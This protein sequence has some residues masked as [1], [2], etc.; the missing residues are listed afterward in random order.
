MLPLELQAP[1]P[2]DPHAARALLSKNRSLVRALA[3]SALVL[4]P[5]VLGLMHL[6]YGELD[7]L[8]YGLALGLGA[9]VA[10][11]ALAMIV[12]ARRALALFVD[13][14]AVEGVVRSVD[15]PPDRS[16]NAYIMMQIEYCDAAGKTRV[17]RCMTIGRA[18]TI[19]RNAGDPVAVLYLPREP[20]RFAVYTPGLGVT[21][22]VAR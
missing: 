12:Q 9:L 6:K 20:S 21:P 5:V 22:G 4:P 11:F 19:D 14:A 15:A 7:G 10:L 16:G 2:R 13:G 1:P 3:A 17:G 8:A 18:R